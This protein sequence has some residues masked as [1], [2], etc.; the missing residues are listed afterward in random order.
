MF[1]CGRRAYPE[2]VQIKKAQDG[3]TISA[4]HTGYCHLPG[5]PRPIREITLRNNREL[6]II[7]RCLGSGA[8]RLSGGWLLAPGWTYKRSERGWEIYMRD[9][10]SLEVRLQGPADLRLSESR[11]W[12]HPEFGLE[13]MADRL[14]WVLANSPSDGS[15]DHLLTSII[16]DAHSVR[17]AILPTRNGG[18]F[19]PRSRIIP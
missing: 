9:C 11:Q 5:S 1:R 7:D 13:T 14:E 4:S 17:F 3:F 12:Y 2:N 8:H 19:G 18:S 6:V 10:G 16:S 15:H